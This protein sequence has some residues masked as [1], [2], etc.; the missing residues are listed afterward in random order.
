MGLEYSVWSVCKIVIRSQNTCIV[1]LFEFVLIG[2]K[3]GIMN[4]GNQTCL[5]RLI[6]WSSHIMIIPKACGGHAGSKKQSYIIEC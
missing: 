6:M 4:Q 1:Y 3:L 5:F 2:W